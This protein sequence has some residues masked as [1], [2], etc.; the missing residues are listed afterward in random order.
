MHGS[1]RDHREKELIMHRLW[2]NIDIIWEGMMYYMGR[3]DD[4]IWEGWIIWEGKITHMGE[5]MYHMGRKDVSY[6]KGRCIIW[7]GRMYHMG[8]KDVSYGKG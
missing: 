3:R 8:R 2:G 7:E 5:M 1:W 6:R 4:R